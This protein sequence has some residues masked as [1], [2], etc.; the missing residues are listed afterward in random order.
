DIVAASLVV[1][2]ASAIETMLRAVARGELDEQEV[3]ARL[4]VLAPAWDV[5]APTFAER[6]GLIEDA[7][8]R[9]KLAAGAAP[10]ADR[11]ANQ[12]RDMADEYR[13][14]IAIAELAADLAER[15]D[16]LF[17]RAPWPVRRAL[18]A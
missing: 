8:A 1:R 3:F 4:G 6:P 13:A 10:P 18:L 12:D 15:D 7:I 2:P 17:A 5:A 14:E 9:A 11:H 16:M